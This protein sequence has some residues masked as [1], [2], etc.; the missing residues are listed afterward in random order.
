LDSES[1]F[2]VLS[3]FIIA[4]VIR[5]GIFP[6]QVWITAAFSEGPLLLTA[7]L[8]N[9][10][11]GAYLVAR[12]VLPMVRDAESVAIPVLT[13]LA[14]L[15]AGYTS[16]IAVAEKSPRRLIALLLASQSAF[17]LAGMASARP[18]GRA[19]ALAQWIAIALASVGLASV[20]SLIEARVQT[21]FDTSRYLGLAAQMPR[22]AVFFAVFGL[23]SV[24]LPGTF[25]CWAEGVLFRSAFDR[26]HFM[27]LVLPLATALNAIHVSRLCAR[28]FLG[29]AGREF[30][31]VPD[32]R[33][34]ERNVL[35]ACAALLV[36]TGIFPG[37][38]MSRIA[39]ATGSIAPLAKLRKVSPLIH[40]ASQ[41]APG[42]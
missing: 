38:V 12:A 32:A 26:W 30:T 1:S 36:L 23:A 24:G 14:L 40:S 41:T 33:P 31:G 22:A 39:S 11:A 13:A 35:V 2:W 29:S 19:G 8:L 3:A 10:H 37:P 18:E 7:L 6:F 20:Y 27:S 9:T 15:T 28:L 42:P 5:K 25:G 21:R 34:R 17:I 16:I 4:A